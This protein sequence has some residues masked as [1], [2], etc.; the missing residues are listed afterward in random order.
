MHADDDLR[1]SQADHITV[2]QLPLLYRC[3]V[4]SGAVV[5]F[6]VCEQCDLPITGS[7]VT[8]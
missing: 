2:G 3:I 7:Q 4:N 1:V 5:E 8:A 6:Q